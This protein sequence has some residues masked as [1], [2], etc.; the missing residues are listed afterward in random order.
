MGMSG[1]CAADYATAA[2]LGHA[3]VVQ[4]PAVRSI[5]SEELWLER[6]DWSDPPQPT[7]AATDAYIAALFVELCRSGTII[8]TGQ[9][10]TTTGGHIS[11]EDL[12]V[13]ARLE[14]DERAALVHA[15]AGVINS[16]AQAVYDGVTAV[17][18]DHPAD[19]ARQI[20][21]SL[22]AAHAIWTPLGLALALHGLSCAASRSGPRSEPLVF[23]ADELLHRL[24]LAF[25]WQQHVPCLATPERTEQLIS[26]T[27]TKAAQR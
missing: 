9:P 24:D 5:G 26:F 16:D 21:R 6:P 14:A 4:V 20:G 2:A 8:A 25:R 7:D 11:C 15:V 10:H 1:A 27:N 13:V 3:A 19:L 17:C 23:L 18:R 22:T 12:C